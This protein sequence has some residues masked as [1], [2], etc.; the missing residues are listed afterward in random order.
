MP[1]SLS[2][3]DHEN[4][5]SRGFSRRQLGKIASVLTAGAALPFYNESAFAQNAMRGRGEMSPDAVRINSNENPMGPCPEALE[6]I[7]QV[8]KFG[9]R[10]SP[11][12][13]QGALTKTV[14]SLEGLKPDYISLFAGSSD[15]LQRVHLR[16]HVA[17]TQLCDGRSGL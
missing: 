9:G 3:N 12:N 17:D 6:A 15:P 4:F 16:V 14:A 8:A 2:V 5:L 7:C 13:E 1:Q 10:Y 11:N